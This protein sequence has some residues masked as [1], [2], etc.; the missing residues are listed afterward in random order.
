ME[1]YKTKVKLKLSALKLFDFDWRVSSKVLMKSG[2]NFGH[3]ARM[4]SN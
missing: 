3:F 4:V 1:Q 2:T